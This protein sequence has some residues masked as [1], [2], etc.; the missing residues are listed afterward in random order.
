MKFAFLVTPHTGGTFSVF[1]SLRAELRPHGVDL[2][3]M[4]PADRD[5][6]L[7]DPPWAVEAMSG[8][9]IARHGAGLDAASGAD[10]GA[11]QARE[12]AARLEAGGY[13]GV[14]VNVL[15]DQ[16]STNLVRH[17]P[18][19]LLRIMIV[20]NITPGTYAAAAAIRDHVHAVVCVCDRACEDLRRRR[21]FDPARLSVIRNA[22]TLPD[23]GVEAA[24]RSTEPGL[25]T[26][27]LGRIEDASKGVLLLP[28]ILDRVA[29]D[30]T[31][32]V[33]GD[34][35]DAPRLRAALSRLGARAMMI[36]AAAPRDVPALLA[37]HDA[38]IMPSRF[39]GMPMALIEAMAMGCV[40]VASRI[41]GV[42]NTIVEHERNGLLFPVGSARAAA[43]RLSA[44][45]ADPAW[46]AE[47]SAA[48]RVTARSLYG[49][50]RMGEE[51]RG[52]ILAL[53]KSPPPIAAPLPFEEWRLPGGLRSGL[54]T[55][56]PRPLKNA[57]RLARERMRPCLGV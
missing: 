26:L 49:G 25:R 36:G 23:L 38:L 41:D 47:L 13:D 17:L 5:A 31:L 3:W 6:L 53:Q 57:L 30:V 18:S 52:L 50:A 7:A 12:M 4:G 1:A 9:A 14:F 29:G 19:R 20:H 15:S 16:A 43:S 54:R 21:G 8:E 48:A 24:E 34:G 45:R 40:P 56:A 11:A 44:L 2:R 32:T 37:H 28:A 39:E 55:Y 42:T 35:P 22:V 27:F 33:A 51:Y 46:R 10:S